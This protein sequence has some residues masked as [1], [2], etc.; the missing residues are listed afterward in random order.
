MLD[1]ES[2][3]DYLTVVV[4]RVRLGPERDAKVAQPAMSAKPLRLLHDKNRRSCTSA[5]LWRSETASLEWPI[6]RPEFSCRTS[7]SR[8]FEHSARDAPPL[9]DGSAASA[10]ASVFALERECLSGCPH[11][12]F[13]FLQEV[14][15]RPSFRLAGTLCGIGGLRARDRGDYRPKRLRRKTGCVRY[16]CLRTAFSSGSTCGRA[17]TSN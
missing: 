15:S 17:R 12:P 10:S 1:S 6:V 7:L 13:P 9:F 3:R 11:I 16:L 5:A 2:S 14:S 8:R 4:C